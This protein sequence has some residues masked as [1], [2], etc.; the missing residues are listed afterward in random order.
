MASYRILI[1]RQMDR[2]TDEPNYITVIFLLKKEVSE[3][4]LTHL[5]LCYGVAS[6]ELQ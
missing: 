2:Q 3:Y 1:D 6:D 5:E 4:N